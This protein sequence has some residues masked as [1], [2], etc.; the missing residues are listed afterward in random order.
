MGQ[1]CCLSY[2]YC[3]P[4]GLFVVTASCLRDTLSLGLQYVY[5]VHPEC[6]H[7]ED[8]GV[9]L[10]SPAPRLLSTPPPSS[11]TRRHSLGLP[12]GWQ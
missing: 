5:L 7:Q 12:K 4:D 11:L 3:V 8:R 6:R 1:I 10:L 9:F 2:S